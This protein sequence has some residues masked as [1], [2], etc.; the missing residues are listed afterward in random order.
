MKITRF[1]IFSLLLSCKCGGDLKQNKTDISLQGMARNEQSAS[2]IVP[3]HE[4]R[5]KMENGNA[6]RLNGYRN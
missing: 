2:L 5:K 4:K 1:W 6:A 3:G